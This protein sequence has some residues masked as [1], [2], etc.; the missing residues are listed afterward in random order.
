MEEDEEENDIEEEVK[1]KVTAEIFGI[2]Y[3]DKEND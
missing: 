1:D 2:N 3:E